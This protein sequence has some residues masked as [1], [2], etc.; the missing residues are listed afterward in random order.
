MYE[1]SMRSE[2]THVQVTCQSVIYDDKEKQGVA[3]ND[4][5]DMRQRIRLTLQE[6]KAQIKSCPP[7][8]LCFQEIQFRI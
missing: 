6:E 2:D 1:Q 8:L 3:E 4:R 7:A 5:D